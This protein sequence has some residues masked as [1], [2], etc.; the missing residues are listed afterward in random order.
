M[1]NKCVFLKEYYSGD[2]SVLC[3]LIFMISEV[4]KFVAVDKALMFVN[5]YVKSLSSLFVHKFRKK[6]LSKLGFAML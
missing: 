1:K 3:S 2:G 4:L 6:W 5:F